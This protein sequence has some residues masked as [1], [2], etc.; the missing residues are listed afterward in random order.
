M[1]HQWQPQNTQTTPEQFYQKRP[2]STKRNYEWLKREQCAALQQTYN[3]TSLCRRDV[4]NMSAAF[5]HPTDHL[6]SHCHRSSGRALL[7]DYDLNA[8]W[9]NFSFHS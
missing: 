3:A 2:V 7:A 5:A 4:A 1:N 8:A 6:L 9:W